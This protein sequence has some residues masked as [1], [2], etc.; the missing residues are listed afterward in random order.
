[1]IEIE[2]KECCSG[3]HACA[4]ICPQKCIEMREDE[5]GFLYPYVDVSKCVECK[6]CEK[7]CSIINH[8][9]PVNE[10]KA[11]GCINKDE[12]VRMQSSSGGVFTLLAEYIINKGGSVYGA[13]FDGD[14]EVEHIEIKDKKDIGKLRGSKYTQSKI[15]NTYSKVKQELEAGALVYFSGTSCQID[16]LISYLQK[17]Y[18][19]L[20]CQDI[21]CHGVPSPKVW[22]KYLRE[23]NVQ[24]RGKPQKVNFREK[25]SGWNQYSMQIDYSDNSY[26]CYYGDN[27]YMKA[28]LK[29]MDLRPSCYE[30]H[31]KSLK[32]KSDITLADFWGIDNI[33]S[34]MNDNK[35]VSL[36]LVNTRK[37]QKLFEAIRDNMDYKSVNLQEALQYN[38]SAYKS[39]SRPEIRD[40]FFKILDE[41][42]LEEYIA[43]VTK[44]SFVTQVKRKV[45]LLVSRILEKLKKSF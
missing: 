23:K 37:G 30:C 13:A 9:E 24:Y 6:L 4:N 39:S 7:V 44:V 31:S 17:P 28:F 36:V 42:N 20:I 14:F 12:K 27:A 21:I 2:K 45:Y 22:R 26:R 3:C 29:N 32:R 25:T 35:G 15:G 16:G 34:E 33:C 10:S 43:K 1:M 38:S 41:V 40:R 19:N 8:K 18:D 5:E 11:Y